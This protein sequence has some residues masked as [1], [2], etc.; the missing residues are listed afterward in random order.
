MFSRFFIDRPIFSCVISLMIL[1]AGAVAFVKLPIAQ[2]PDIVPPVV[3]VSA[4]YPGA[5]PETLSETVAIPI[6]QEVNGVDNMIYMS[7]TLSNDGSYTLNVTFEVGTDPDMATVLVQ[8]RVSLAEPRLPDDVTRLGVSTTKQSTN[9]LG[10]YALREK[11]R[12]DEQGNQLPLEKSDLYLSNYASI[13]I[14]DQVARVPGVGK[15]K[16][17][18]SKDYSM[19][20]WLDPD[21]LAERNISVQEVSSII[22]EQNVQV[23]SGQVGANPVPDGQ[24]LTLSVI[25]QGRLADVE[26]FENLVVR[27]DDEGRVL[28]LKDLGRIELARYDYTTQSSFE[29]GPSSTLAIYQLPGANAIAVAEG[30]KKLIEK[31]KPQLDENNLE[32]VQAYDSTLFINATIDEVLETLYLAVLIVIAVVFVF[33]Q[34]WRAALIPTLVIPV[35]LV[36]SF[37]LM[38]LFG[39]S[40]NTL[41]TFG[42]VLVIGIVVD[43]AIVVVENTQ[44]ILTLH[45]ELSPRDAAKKSMSEVTG[46]V[47]ATTCVLCSVFIPTTFVAGLVGRFYTQFALTIV[48]AVLISSLC[49]LTLSPALCAIFLRPETGKK[50]FFFFRIFN[51]LFDLFQSA[52]A[53][54]LGMAV[55]VPFLILILWVALIIA[56]AWGMG[57]MPHGFLPSEDQGVLFVDVSLPDGAS[58][59]RTNEVARKINEIVS[60][61]P[62]KKTCLTV[63][64]YSMINSYSSSNTML[65]VIQL[66]PWDERGPDRHADVLQAK[67]MKEFAEKIPEARVLVFQP[68]AIMGIGTSDAAECELLD[69]RGLG[70]NALYDAANQESDLSMKTGLFSTVYSGFR[71]TVPEIYIDV[72]REK[73]KRM[74]IDLSELFASLQTYLGSSYV[75]DFN[76]YER[77]FRVVA[78]ADGEHRRRPEQ[79]MNLPLL[80]SDG[81]K[82]P[83][84]AVADIRNIVGPQAL[85]RFNMS[86]STM[87]SAYTNPGVSS[88]TAMDTMENVAKSL[89]EGFTVG[90]SGMSYQQRQTGSTIVVVFILAII[91]G[92]LTLA[93]QYE[94]WSAPLIIMMAVP[95]GVSGA[96]LAVALCALDIN[97]YTQIGLILMVGL[98]AKNAILITEFA[99]DNHLKE[100]M[101]ITESA[102]AAG[103]QRLRPIIMTSCAFI[104]GVIP[105][106]IATGA[107]A[108]SRNAIGIAVCGGM[109]EETMVGIV[110]SPVLFILLTRV[111]EFGM[112]IFRKLLGQQES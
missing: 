15:A 40:I 81:E 9:M 41:T 39:F 17:M 35:S 83:L 112:K 1:V 20:V 106:A 58:L 4:S 88:G 53:G 46:P 13:F 102:T 29:G 61:L 59:Q 78:Q 33:L 66:D 94:S 73:A 98:S 79:I 74:G 12:Y 23:A 27:T 7:S 3:Q 26:Q 103:R 22:S 44:R 37:F 63:S 101:G 55:R 97:I 64:G 30:V 100:G 91:F 48:G 68:P 32:L 82:V 8:N 76:R 80:N 51:W 52:Y 14:K 77:V 84:R 57:V 89:P 54:L 56:L 60:P 111:S 72:D 11:P 71:P 108:R 36:G 93:A 6:E 34:D 87:L 45:P 65:G 47:L 19:R 42:L 38:M 49:A 10:L 110:V 43:D 2:F 28:K 104:L 25:T 18:D 92:F 69:Q 75:N 62:G 95:L 96:I 21:I 109:L 107:G 67:L 90:W 5:S 50:K 85:T 16:L 31:L 99:R 105:L 70:A 24:M 86:S